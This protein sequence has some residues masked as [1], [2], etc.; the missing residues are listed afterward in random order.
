MR[1]APAVE[2]GVATGS[3]G[4]RLR[5]ARVALNLS[6]IAVLAKIFGFAEKFVVA[7]FFGTGDTA[8]VY[9]AVTGIV[10]SIVW[11]VRELVNP[12]LLP[13]F[14]AG[15]AFEG[16]EPG[17]LFRRV[18]L[19]TAR[20]LVL[21]AIG[22]VVFAPLLTR[23][24]VPGFT[25]VKWHTACR[26]LRTL[27]PAIPFLGLSMVVY[28]VLNAH[29]RFIRAAVPEA[30]FKL[31]V[32]L[33]LLALLPMAGI[34]ALAIVMG[35][36]GALCLLVQLSFVP[37]R[38]FI[39]AVRADGRADA[40]FRQMR[41]LMHP[42]LVGV[43]FSHVNGL[44]DNVLASTLPTGQ[45][46]FLGYSKKLIDA[47]LLIGPV[48]LSTVIYS[49]LSHLVC[50]NDYRSFAALMGRACR[51]LIYLS[52]PA[53]CILVT[54]RRPLI[55]LLFQRGQFGIDSTVGTSEAFLVYALG[56]TALSLETLLVHGFFAMSDTK[57]PIKIG[58][59]CSLVD[60]A[61]ALILLRPLQYLGIAWAF[62][63]ARTLKVALL[64]ILLNRRLEGV[65]GSDIA[66]FAVRLALCTFALWATLKL[67]VNLHC[68]DSFIH[69]AL[70]GL[71]LPALGAGL[72]FALCSHLLRIEEFKAVAA[73]MKHGRAGVKT[74]SGGPK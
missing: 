57:T 10:L 34:Y 66:S 30:A 62:V 36:G 25:G 44:V 8:D 15:L 54:L 71:L 9:F 37:E 13:V 56:L 48:A 29:K 52:V 26:L 73:L 31:F 6:T 60:V 18:F 49:H 27:A 19:L 45:L 17:L 28:T 4:D 53:A 59:L 21:A 2:R 5:L 33:G 39:W 46:S 55:G 7:Q 63:I 40:A 11:L 68:S 67:L 22:V 64:G 42:L 3:S 74:L 32:V 23:V 69:T 35:A 61:L 43:L 24:L 65:F 20:L 51:L 50:T 14:V 47:L 58:I 16:D 38:R 41:R 1:S 70:V 72:I 12:S